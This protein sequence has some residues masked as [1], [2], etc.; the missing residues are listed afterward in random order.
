MEQRIRTADLAERRKKQT[1]KKLQQFKDLMTGVYVNYQDLVMTSG[2][3]FSRAKTDMLIEELVE[4]VDTQRALSLRRIEKYIDNNKEKLKNDEKAYEV[5]QRLFSCN[6]PLSEENKAFYRSYF[7][8]LLGISLYKND[9]SDDFNREFIDGTFGALIAH[10]KY[11]VLYNN[12]G[13]IN[14]NLIMLLER[15]EVGYGRQGAMGILYDI[16]CAYRF[17]TGNHITELFSKD[18]RNSAYQQMSDKEK[19]VYDD[20][21]SIDPLL[22]DYFWGT[23]ETCTPTE[24][25]EEGHLY[26]SSISRKDSY[27]INL[28]DFHENEIDVWAAYFINKKRFKESCQIVRTGL[29]DEGIRQDFSVGDSGDSTVSCAIE[30]FMAQNGYSVFLD[31]DKIFPAYTYLNKA[32]KISMKKVDG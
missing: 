17:I 26:E 19:K 27:S 31:D 4:C 7:Y 3:K 15:P 29:I 23:F 8:L 32:Y 5:C 6:R 11:E 10:C 18:E 9:H 30:L 20:P 24:M 22:I 13:D 16:I 1:E 28:P 2:G 25:V 12:Y 21:T 14:R